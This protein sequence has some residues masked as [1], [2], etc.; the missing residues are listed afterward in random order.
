M[1]FFPPHCSHKLQP[2]DRTVF[3]PFKKYLNSAGDS[4]TINNP[5]KTMTIYDIPIT[6]S[7]AYPLSMTPT[8]I[9]SGFR[10]TGIY[11][12]NRNIFSDTDFAPSYVTD[13]ADPITKNTNVESNSSF[14]GNVESETDIVISNSSNIP[15]IEQSYFDMSIFNPE[16]VQSHSKQFSTTS[17]NS[18]KKSNHCVSD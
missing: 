9:Q 12:F 15:S 8:N 6:V 2:F 4:W 10:C 14:N 5:G 13:R 17:P 11:P 7:H 3:G 1:L 16:A 18:A